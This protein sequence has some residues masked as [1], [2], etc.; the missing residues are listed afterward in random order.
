MPNHNE[1]YN[2]QADLYELMISKQPLFTDVIKEIRPYKNLDVLDLGAGTGRFSSFIADEANSIICTDLSQSMLEV[3]EKKLMKQ[4]SVRNWITMQADH[5]NIPIPDSTIDLV[6]SGWS[7]CYLASSTNAK[8][9]EDLDIVMKEIERVLK[10]NGTIII[11]ET[12]GTGT[13]EPNPPD[14]LRSYYDQLENQYA[15]NHKWMRSDYVFENT[16]EAEKNTEFFFGSDISNKVKSN[17]WST[18]PECAG[19]WWKHM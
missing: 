12:M 15:F 13:T 5:R 2:S 14:F 19:V 17:E 1:V 8:W 16:M 10:P 3:L 7:I 9:K 18:V 6:I 11:I 4:R